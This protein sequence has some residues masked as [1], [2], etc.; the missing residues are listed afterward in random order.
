M[1]SPQIGD[2]GLACEV[3]CVRPGSEFWPRNCQST[4][5]SGQRFGGHAMVRNLIFLTLALAFSTAP[6]A[7]DDW[8]DCGN[9]SQDVSIITA[10]SAPAGTQRKPASFHYD[11]AFSSL[12]ASIGNQVAVT[13][14]ARIMYSKLSAS[15][16]SRRPVSVSA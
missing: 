6:V 12:T 15:R 3:H 16:Q 14:L 7:A 1:A 11:G 9:D 10:A 13:S 5:V 4:A 8:K 2:S